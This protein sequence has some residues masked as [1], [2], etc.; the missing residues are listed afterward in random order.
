MPKENNLHIFQEITPLKNQDVLVVI[1]SVNNGFDYPIHNHPEYEINLVSGI[2][3]TRVVGDSTERYI[4]KDLVILGPYLWHKWDGDEHL[5]KNGQPYRVLT[6]QFSL[7]LFNAPFF[8]KEWFFKIKKLLQDSSRGIR[9][10]GDTIDK[11]YSMLTGMIH[12]QGMA[13]VLNFIQLL[14]LLAN[15]SEFAFLSSPGFSPALHHTENTRIQLAYSY[16][17]KNYTRIDFRMNQVA[18]ALN[19]SESAF[20]HFFQKFAFRSFTQF[21]IDLRIGHACK[22]LL[23]TDQTIAQ[24]SDASGFNNLANFNRLFRKYRE[25]TPM[26]YRKRYTGNQHFDWANQ[27]TPWQFVP[28]KASM[29]PILKPNLSTTRV[30]H[31]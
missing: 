10:Y 4:E 7:E 28:N 3:G 15:S 26:E 2:S 8:Q 27:L 17:M 31:I 9:Y 24:I 22:M 25:C 12:A 1:D 19:M 23:D 11:A 16:I 6:V 30:V 13:G 21:L 20:S 14:D 5:Q 29:N 18:E